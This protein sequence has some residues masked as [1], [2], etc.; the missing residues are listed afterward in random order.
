MILNQEFAVD[1]GSGLRWRKAIV[2]FLWP[3]TDVFDL[4]KYTRL[5]CAFEIIQLFSLVFCV[6][7]ALHKFDFRLVIKGTANKGDHKRNS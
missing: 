3:A 1:L 5:K 6:F 4:K 7:R 2:P